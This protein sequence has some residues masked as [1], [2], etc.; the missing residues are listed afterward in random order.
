VA[1]NQL[2]RE[3]VGDLSLMHISKCLLM[4]DCP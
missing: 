3:Y 4:Q 2:G 1:I